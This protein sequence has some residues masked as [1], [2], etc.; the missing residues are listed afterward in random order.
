MNILHYAKYLV[1]VI[2]VI[3]AGVGA[4]LADGILTADE[5]VNLLIIGLGA[6]LTYLVPNLQAGIGSYAKLIVQ[7]LTAGAVLLQ[8]SLLDGVTA[9]EWFQ[10][11][12]AVLGAFT[13]YALP[14][15]PELV[16]IGQHTDGSTT[17]VYSVAAA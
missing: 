8:S 15:H 9:G 7:A 10:I 12:A 5:A 3:V 4:A 17:S 16:A 6:I 11:A 1:A 2:T 13:V 14:N